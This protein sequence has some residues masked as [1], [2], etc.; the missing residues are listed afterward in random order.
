LAKNADKYGQKNGDI[1]RGRPYICLPEAAEN[2]RVGADNGA[3]QFITKN[4]EL[5][6]YIGISSSLK[7]RVKQSLHR[8]GQTLRV[9]GG[10]GSLDF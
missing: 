8:P 4:G 9:P 7:V 1:K 6:H 5:H 10:S 2:N 3:V